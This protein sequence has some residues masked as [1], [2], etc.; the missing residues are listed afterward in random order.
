MADFQNNLVRVPATISE[1]LIYLRN[2]KQLTLSEVGKLFNVNKS[3]V[4]RW[5]TNK[6]WA[7]HDTPNKRLIL[8]QLVELYQA[9]YG[10][11]LHGEP[12]I[13]KENSN[14]MIIDDDKTSLS[15]M[16]MI[17]KSFMSTEFNLLNFIEP[18][19]ALAWAGNNDSVLVFC[20][21]RMPDMKGDIF[22]TKLRKIE[23]YKTTPVIAITQVREMDIPDKLYNAGAT[24]VLQKPIDQEKLQAVLKLYEFD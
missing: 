13:N 18:E 3:T 24:H 20:D 2:K 8:L 21:Y 16:T 1:R 23:T 6:Y 14:I 7:H 10:W 5:E 17:I 15:I 19:K 12:G 22:I 9:D 4:L 11:V